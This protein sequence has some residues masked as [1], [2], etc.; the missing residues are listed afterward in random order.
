MA[1]GVYRTDKPGELEALKI[2]LSA[3]TPGSDILAR[4]EPGKIRSSEDVLDIET[5]LLRDILQGKLPIKVSKELRAWAE[6]LHSSITI[7]EARR[8]MTNGRV[9]NIRTLMVE[10]QMD[11]PEIASHTSPTWAQA[12]RENVIVEVES[13]S[14]NGK[15]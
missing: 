4:L 10:A 6:L 13:T 8:V 11:I 1:Q 12:E 9:S 5:M 3:C 2:A 14:I 15:E 7:L